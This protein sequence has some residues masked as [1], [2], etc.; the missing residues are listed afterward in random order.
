MSSL[1]IIILEYQC[2]KKPNIGISVWKKAAKVQ[3]NKNA[4]AGSSS[5]K[6]SQYLPFRLNFAQ[7]K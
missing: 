7:F 3:A 6:M 1:E 2:G 5:E 4:N